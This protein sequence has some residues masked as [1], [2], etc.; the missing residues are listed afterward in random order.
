MIPSPALQERI[1]EGIT[2]LEFA[3]VSCKDSAALPKRKQM[4]G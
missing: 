2:Y 4:M 1:K 3:L